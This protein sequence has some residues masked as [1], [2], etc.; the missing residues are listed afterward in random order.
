MPAVA[1]A[2]ETPS[3][4]GFAADPRADRIADMR[5]FLARRRPQSAAEAL[6]FLRAAYPDAPLSLRV[7]ACGLGEG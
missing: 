2:A 5:A 6:R 7:A 4:T 1:V 3:R